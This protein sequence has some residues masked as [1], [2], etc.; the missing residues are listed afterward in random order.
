MVDPR[1]YT[2]KPPVSLESAAET[3]GSKIFVGNAQ[4]QIY[5][6]ASL[7]QIKSS[8]IAFLKNKILLKGF[9]P[10]SGVLIV[11]EN[12]LDSVKEF[13]ISILVHADPDFAF[14]LIADLLIG[15][16]RSLEITMNIS[17]DTKIHKSAQLSANV[18]I[19]DGVVIGKNTFIE[20]NV[21]IGCGVK[22]GE[23]CVI[24]AGA[25]ISFADLG[26]RVKISAGVVIGG[27]GLGI[28][29]SDDQLIDIPHF[30]TVQIHDNVSI[31]SNST[32]DRGQFTKTII[33]ENT[34]I[35]NLVQVAH[36]VVIGRNCIFAGH[37]GISGS[38]KI[39]D[40]V[41]MGGK[42][43][44]ADNLNIGSDVS[45]YASSGLMN[46]IPDGEI[47]GGT[48]AVPYRELARSVGIMRKLVRE[49]RS[50][51]KKT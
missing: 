10:K 29:K 42:V 38:V 41:L 18:I 21:T 43:G 24:G 37:V 5:S 20:P 26:N 34:K 11:N 7:E 9:N 36:N 14:S 35:D 44:I 15:H 3:S 28:A 1:F 8:K 40:N 30:G 32:I 51:K 4:E 47:W 12:L 46:N 50:G 13:P 6:V 23:D 19:G 27:D 49:S 16:R 17:N 22:I 45:I 25:H 2:V 31:G 39:G 48:P 33:G